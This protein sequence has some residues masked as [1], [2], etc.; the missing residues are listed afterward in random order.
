M[1]KGGTMAVE[2]KTIGNSG[3][4]SLG[5]EHAGK[6][7]L[8]EQLEDGVWLIKTALVIP[9]NELWL[10]EEPHKSKLD[11]AIAWAESHPPAPSDIDHIER[12]LRRR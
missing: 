1:Q 11:K 8:V 2:L 9:E 7:V 5:K 6:P 12:K 3:Q 4:I 10:H